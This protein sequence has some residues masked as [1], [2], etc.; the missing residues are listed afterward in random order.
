MVSRGMPGRYDG[1]QKLSITMPS[2]RT[3]IGPR[4]ATCPSLKSCDVGG[5]RQAAAGRERRSRHRP[6][7]LE[8]YSEL[9]LPPLKV[10]ACGVPAPLTLNDVTAAV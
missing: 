10:S 4:P 9:I 3:L 1:R 8:P 5:C 2:S 6:A 7:G